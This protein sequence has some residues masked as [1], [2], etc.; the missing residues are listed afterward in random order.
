MQDG[1]HG[2]LLGLGGHL[3]EKI[4]M[5]LT[6]FSL[7]LSAGLV[8][9]KVTAKNMISFLLIAIFKAVEVKIQRIWTE[10]IG[11]E[12]AVEIG[13]VPGQTGC[14]RTHSGRTECG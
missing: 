2:N 9:L 5:L 11:I 4:T 7:K 8:L 1:L 13:V 10:P 14:G 6:L 12:S 3:R